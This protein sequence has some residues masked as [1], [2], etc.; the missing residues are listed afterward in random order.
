MEKGAARMLESRMLVLFCF[1]RNL[2]R[3]SHNRRSAS[4]SPPAEALRPSP[5][6][7]QRATLRRR[8][9]P[10]MPGGSPKTAR[11]F[12]KRTW[13]ITSSLRK[14]GFLPGSSFFL[15]PA[16]IARTRQ[17]LFSWF[18]RRFPISLSIS[19]FQLSHENANPD[20]LAKPKMWHHLFE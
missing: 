2:W 10:A 18:P 5:R 7:Q 3:P 15:H 12:P 8:R 6:V 20:L 9:R 1:V 14:V 11:P 17:E 16:S 19:D 13:T 4:R